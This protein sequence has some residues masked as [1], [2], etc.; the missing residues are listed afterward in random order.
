MQVSK[1][2]LS[3]LEKRLGEPLTNFI[4]NIKVKN[5]TL[6]KHLNTKISRT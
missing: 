4:P 6:N 1:K 5:I 2:T 3:A